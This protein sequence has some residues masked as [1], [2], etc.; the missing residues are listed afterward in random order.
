MINSSWF[1]RD[2]P[3]FKTESPTARK[4]LQPW[5]VTLSLGQEEKVLFIELWPITSQC[6]LDYSLSGN[7]VFQSVTTCTSPQPFCSDSLV[8]Q[9]KLF[10]FHHYSPLP[11]ITWDCRYVGISLGNIQDGFSYGHQLGAE[12]H[13]Q[14]ELLQVA[15]STQWSQG[16]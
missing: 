7:Q 5:L 9:K 8:A 1:A 3:N 15:L 4:P 12:L 13:C 6:P 2:F 16:S 11:D 14:P 10:P